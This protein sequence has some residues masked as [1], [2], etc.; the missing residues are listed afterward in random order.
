MNKDI[1]KNIKRWA[2]EPKDKNNP[3][4]HLFD[5]MK[6][7]GYFSEHENYYSYKRKVHGVDTTSEEREDAYKEWKKS[8]PAQE[9]ADFNEMFNE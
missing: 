8:L 9:Q 6:K 4:R 3:L 2:N 1:E 5:F 7:H